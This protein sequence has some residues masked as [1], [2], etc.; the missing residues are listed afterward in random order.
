[1]LNMIQKQQ[2]A[3]RPTGLP[4]R[5]LSMRMRTPIPSGK[6]ANRASRDDSDARRMDGGQ[7]G[8]VET[9]TDAQ[10]IELLNRLKVGNLRSSFAQAIFPYERGKYRSRGEWA[11]DVGKRVASDIRGHP[12]LR[13]AMERT[14]Y[15]S[16]QKGYTLEQRI[17]LM[18]FYGASKNSPITSNKKTSL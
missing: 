3:G 12:C 11:R 1:M 5:L 7:A 17:L 8:R 10:A 14:G 9:L 4:D 2:R 6:S 13:L 15:R 16:G 18:K